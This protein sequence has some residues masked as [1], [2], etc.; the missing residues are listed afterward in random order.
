MET[1]TSLRQ[2]GNYQRAGN[3]RLKE[4]KKIS[5]LAFINWGTSMSGVIKKLGILILW[6]RKVY[7]CLLTTGNR[8]KLSPKA[9]FL[10][11]LLCNV[12]C[13]YAY[14]GLKNSIVES[15]GHILGG[16]LILVLLLFLLYYLGSRQYF[17]IFASVILIVVVLVMAFM[18]Y[19]NSSTKSIEPFKA[20]VS[21]RT[22]EVY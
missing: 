5:P 11:L 21:D 22:D 17:L 2:E 4:H 13:D 10:F 18:S 16:C 9:I 8:R 1:G 12:W 15:K 20:G 14:A 6:Y 7:I 19:L 3:A